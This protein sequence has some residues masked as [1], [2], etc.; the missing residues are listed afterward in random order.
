MKS[1]FSPKE[2]AMLSACL[3][4]SLRREKVLTSTIMLFAVLIVCMFFCLISLNTDGKQDPIKLYLYFLASIQG[5]VLLCGASVLSSA[6][7]RE[8][9]SGTLDMHRITPQNKLAQIVGLL[10]GAPVVFSVM[11]LGLCPIILLLTLMSDASVVEVFITQISTFLYIAFIYILLLTLYLS[12]NLDK[13]KNLNNQS[14]YVVFLMIMIF[15]SSSLAINNY[16]SSFALSITP[17]GFFRFILGISEES[18]SRHSINNGMTSFL[19]LLIQVG[20]QLPMAALA[21]SISIRRL[22]YPNRSLISKLHAHLITVIF[23]CMCLWDFIVVLNIPEDNYEFLLLVNLLVLFL[24]L[25]FV[26]SVTPNRLMF[27]KG[28][29]AKKRD[30]NTHYYF[31]DGSTNIYWLI[32]YLIMAGIFVGTIWCITTQDED[33]PMK[34]VKLL[35]YLP[36]FGLIAILQLTSFAA[37]YER[38]ALSRNARKFRILFITLFVILWVV[39][40]ILGI[41]LHSLLEILSLLCFLPSPFLLA[42]IQYIVTGEISSTHPQLLSNTVIPILVF[43]GLLTAGTVFWTT[44]FRRQFIQGISRKQ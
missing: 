29:I 42:Y 5:I 16:Q 37:V 12:S 21:I 9:L 14:G 7:L 1:L 35:G 11:A 22:T 6:I 20:V 34:Q 8:Y 38:F 30:L 19:A 41:I 28:I 43:Y 23:F 39:F 40:P 32:P 3:R 2:N 25:F 33:I 24:G 26:V 13:F 36:V 18:G 31:C 10:L 15:M 4:I 44:R 27:L 17:Y